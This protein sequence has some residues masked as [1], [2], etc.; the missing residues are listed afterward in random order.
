MGYDI[1]VY[2]GSEPNGDRRGNRAEI[3][4]YPHPLS[5]NRTAHAMSVRV[6]YLRFL[7]E[8]LRSPYNRRTNFCPKVINKTRAV[9]ARSSQGPRTRQAR[10]IFGLRSYDF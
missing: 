6:P 9:T 3:V 5:G 1:C 2:N 8:Y 10:S 7:I 4:G